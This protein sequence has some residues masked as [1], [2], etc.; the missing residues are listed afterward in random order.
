[1]KEMK[2]VLCVNGD[3]SYV[4]FKT[5]NINDLSYMCGIWVQIGVGFYKYGVTIPESCLSTRFANL[6][7]GEGPFE[8]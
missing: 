8:L 7:P 6:Q 2:T 4:L 3:S 1:M 5:R